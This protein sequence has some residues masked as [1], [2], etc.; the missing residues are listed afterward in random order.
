M[1]RKIIIPAAVCLTASCHQ[2]S[3]GPWPSRLPLG[4]AIHFAEPIAPRMVS[5]LVLDAHS[6]TPINYAVVNVVGESFGGTTDTTGVVRFRLPRAGSFAIHARGISYEE[7]RGSI[8]VTDST[9]FATIVQLHRSYRLPTP[10]VVGSQP[11]SR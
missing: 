3:N 9:G 1:N 2:A 8:A 11:P 5:V 6:G 7:W 10:V 4:P